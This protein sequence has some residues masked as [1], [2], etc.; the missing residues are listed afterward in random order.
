MLETSTHD[1]PAFEVQPLAG[2]ALKWP[3]SSRSAHKTCHAVLGVLARHDQRRELY[4]TEQIARWRKF[5]GSLRSRGDRM[6]VQFWHVGSHASLCPAAAAKSLGDEV[7][8]AAAQAVDAGFDGVELYV[9]GGLT[10]AQYIKAAE[11]PS[12]AACDSS[13]SLRA[14]LLVDVVAAIAA[15]VGP[16]RIRV[17]T[18]PS[19]SGDSHLQYSFIVGSLGIAYRR[20]AR[21][22]M[23]NPA[24]EGV[25]PGGSFLP[26]TTTPA[27]RTHPTADRY[28]P[29]LSGT[30]DRRR[31]PL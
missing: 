3:P 6:F 16:D 31:H 11:L 24:C 1:A 23:W 25:H 13:W 8:H 20:E 9:C 14:R 22:G 21:H 29:V 12:E 15:E 19:L 10:L 30:Q 4:T 2:V 27:T 26:A 17:F 18:M 28:R 7:R 5:N